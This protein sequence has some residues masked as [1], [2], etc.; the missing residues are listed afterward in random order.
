MNDRGMSAAEVLDV[1]RKSDRQTMVLRYPGGMIRTVPAHLQSAAVIWANVP[2][3]VV[4]VYGPD[5]ARFAHARA[6]VL[7]GQKAA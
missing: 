4:G 3:W 2:Q 7:T 1:I 6:L 5:D